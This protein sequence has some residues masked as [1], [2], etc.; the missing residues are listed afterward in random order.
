MTGP[1]VLLAVAGAHLS[2]EALNGELAA[3]G[4]E[5]VRTTTT[6][7]DYRLY[8]LATTPPKPGLVR[9][10]SAGQPIEVEVWRL[11]EPAFGHFVAMLPR[12]MTIGKVSLADG[13]VVC[14]FGCEPG[15]LEGAADITAHGGWRAYQHR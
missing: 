14:G 1:T 12:P 9:V 13:S 11:D 15:A 2:G 6:S 10:P 4:A 3:L 8:A 7:A 5:L